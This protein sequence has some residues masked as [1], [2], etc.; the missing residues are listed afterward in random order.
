LDCLEDEEDDEVLEIPDD[1]D[2][3]PPLSITKSNSAQQVT[4]SKSTAP[5]QSTKQQSTTTTKSTTA[6]QQSKSKKSKR[7]LSSSVLQVLAESRSRETT[8]MHRNME[9][10]VGRDFVRAEQVNRGQWMASCAGQ[11]SSQRWASFRDATYQ[12][13]SSYLPDDILDTPSVSVALPPL[14]TTAVTSSSTAATVSAS[15]SSVATLSYFLKKK[16]CR[17]MFLFPSL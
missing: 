13:I 14:F 16:L 5:Q 7:T 17:L 15:V 2:I 12:L 11:V 8:S 3:A 6:A 10:M 9:D 1:F 4:S